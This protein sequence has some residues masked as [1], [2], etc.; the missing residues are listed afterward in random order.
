MIGERIDNRDMT[1]VVGVSEGNPAIFS[2]KNMRT[3]REWLEQ[4]GVMTLPK[5]VG[6]EPAEWSYKGMN[7]NVLCLLR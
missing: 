2:L 7:Y 3:G 4:P 1:V 6:G 5:T